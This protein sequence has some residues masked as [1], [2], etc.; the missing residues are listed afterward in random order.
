MQ[1]GFTA[2]DRFLYGMTRTIISLF[3][4]LILSSEGWAQQKESDQLGMA[5]EYFQSGKYSEALTI[6][7]RLE[8]T[9]TLNPRFRAYIGVCHYYEWNFEKAALYLDEAIP[10]LDSFSPHE[11]SFYC[12]ACAESHFNTGDYSKALPYYEMMLNLCHDNEKADAYYRIG[13]IHMFNGKW[14]EALD[15]FQSALVYY[16]QYRPEEKARIAQ[17]R[18]MINGCAEKIRGTGHE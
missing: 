10:K 18:N 17:I 8:K 13:F 11:R 15:N 2:G 16:R 5:I 4:I 7:S 3:L 12:F 9:N 14:I 6:F 1:A